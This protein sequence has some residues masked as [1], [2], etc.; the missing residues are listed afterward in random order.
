MEYAEA[1]LLNLLEEYQRLE[2]EQ[3]KEL[4][5]LPPGQLAIRRE[6]GKV[7]YI[8]LLPA[9]DVERGTNKRVRRGITKNEDMIRALARKKYLQISLALL[10]KNIPALKKLVDVHK[11]PTPTN[12]I[13]AMPKT[14]EGLSAEMFLP[15]IRERN[16]WADAAFEQGVNRPE[17]RRHITVKGLRVR[18]KSEVIIATNWMPTE[19]LIVTSRCSILKTRLSVRTSLFYAMGIWSIGSTAGW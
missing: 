15:E 9:D 13:A 18:S 14:C 19:F 6:K 3:K 7:N 12:I 2:R 5:K 1:Y 16:R 8:Q 10:K 11:A 17:E 4:A